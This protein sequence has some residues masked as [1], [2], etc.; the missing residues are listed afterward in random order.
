MHKCCV[1]LKKSADG[2][3][4]FLVWNCGL[5]VTDHL[6]KQTVEKDKQ[7]AP[8]RVFRIANDENIDKKE[9]KKFVEKCLAPSLP[10]YDGRAEIKPE[11]F[12]SHIISQI[13]FLDGV[14]IDSAP[15]YQ[16]D[17]VAPEQGGSAWKVVEAYI[18]NTSIKK[19]N[20]GEVQYEMLKQA[21][22]ELL[23]KYEQDIKG[24]VQFQ[25]ELEQMA[26]LFALKLQ[27]VANDQQFSLELQKAGL[28]L[29]L[30]AKKLI[31]PKAAPTPIEVQRKSQFQRLLANDQE[32]K[33]NPGKWTDFHHA[34]HDSLQEPNTDDFTILPIPVVNN[35]DDAH[36]A[37]QKM[38]EEVGSNKKS[39]RV[40]KQFEAFL[41][42][43][44]LTDDFINKPHQVKA[45]DF[46]LMLQRFVTKYMEASNANS[47]VP[48][49]EQQIAAYSAIAL[50][51][52]ITN[53]HFEKRDNVLEVLY[54]AESSKP[55]FEN[56]M[57]KMPS[58]AHPVLQYMDLLPKEDTDTLPERHKGFEN[59]LRSHYFTETDSRTHER[60]RQIKDVLR[61]KPSIEK[62]YRHIPL[63]IIASEDAALCQASGFAGKSEQDKKEVGNFFNE[64]RKKDKSRYSNIYEDGSLC[65]VYSSL[66]SD[67]AHF[68][69]GN[70]Y[71][72]HQTMTHEENWNNVHYTRD[73]RS[74]KLY[75]SDSSYLSYGENN[76]LEQAHPLENENAKQDFKVRLH[77]RRYDSSSNTP[78]VTPNNIQIRLHA[79][80][81]DKKLDLRRI[82]NQI[83]ATPASQIICA[84]S[85]T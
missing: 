78:K 50:L 72:N 53:K 10:D 22:D 61:R 75:S 23:T 14:E 24:A 4:L 30:K 58:L 51:E 68:L 28:D 12:Q 16:T 46:S 48:Y 13:S 80:N 71:S 65:L 47:R 38:L 49:G 21:L 15:Y 20:S 41:K 35:L 83:G 27:Q 7:H 40:V 26:S 33:F 76:Q 31:S 81:I 32:I 42:S 25:E 8:V 29:I 36:S 9:F 45:H 79:K 73:Q 70:F 3:I 5:G 62:N 6:G 37:M 39:I 69:G 55:L 85:N 64:K 77:A 84:V 63:D 2:E 56:L 19:E 44:P 82:L 34:R 52:L 57:S 43:L 17:V 59:A 74:N 11:E 66:A 60:L 1:S 67:M 54:A 18:Q